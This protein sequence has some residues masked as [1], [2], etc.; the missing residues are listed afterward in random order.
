MNSN[1]RCNRKIAGGLCFDEHEVL[2]FNLQLLAAAQ[3][4]HKPDGARVAI[5]P[6]SSGRARKPAGEARGEHT[7][8]HL[9]DNLPH[10]VEMIFRHGLLTAS[11]AKKF[12]TLDVAAPG[13]Q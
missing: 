13:R 6:A 12:L 2:S 3:V 10:A 9:L 11:G 8:A 4:G 5:G 1:A 7:H